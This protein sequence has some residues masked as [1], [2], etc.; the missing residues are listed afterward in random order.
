MEKKLY[1]VLFLDYNKKLMRK[2]YQKIYFLIYF[3]Y[4]L[5]ILKTILYLVK[6]LKILNFTVYQPYQ[7]HNNYCNPQ[8]CLLWALVMEFPIKFFQS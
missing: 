7:Q 8:I 4:L 3:S 1:L 2:Y 6:K 5:L